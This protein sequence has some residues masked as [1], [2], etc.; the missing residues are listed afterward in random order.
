M[1]GYGVCLAFS[2]YVRSTTK[3][4]RI[5]VG[6]TD[7]LNKLDTVQMLGVI[8]LGHMKRVPL[9]VFLATEGQISS[10]SRTHGGNFSNSQRV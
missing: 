1:D 5:F 9:L 10:G 6:F 3:S 4:P 2:G 8:D 7:S